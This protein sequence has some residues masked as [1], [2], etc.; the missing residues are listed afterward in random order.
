MRLSGSTD[1]CERQK[2]AFSLVPE[3][4]SGEQVACDGHTLH[5]MLFCSAEHCIIICGLCIHRFFN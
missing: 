2:L 3:L 5:H 1:A 4:T